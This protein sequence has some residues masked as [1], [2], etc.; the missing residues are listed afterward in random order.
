[1]PF[2]HR[3]LLARLLVALILLAGAACQPAPFPTPTATA[4]SAPAL[5]PQAEA[6]ATALPTTVVPTPAP[7]PTPTPSPTPVANLVAGVP[8][9]QALVLAGDEPRTLDPALSQDTTS[10][11]Y[12]AHLFSGLVRLDEGLRLQPDLAASWESL[13]DGTR[14]VFHLRP[15]ALFHDGKPVTAYDVAFSLE[16]ATSPTLDSPTA[17]TY[18]SD[19][20]GVA[21]KL[22]GKAG[23][24]AGLHVLDDLTLEIV[25]DAPKVY[26][27]AK[28]TYP[29][30]AVVSKE[31]V[32][33]GPEWSRTANGTGPFRL[34]QWL[35]GQQLV[36]ERNPEFYRPQAGVR[37]VVY[38]FL[39]GAPIRLYEQ[40][41]ID[42]AYIG[43]G[44]LPRAQDP[45][46]G[47]GSDL[48]AYGEMS[49]FY[50]G[51]STKKQ[52][53]D[54]PLVRRAFAMALD[55]ERLA[56]AGQQKHLL[57]ANG[58]LPQG[59][60]GY[61]AGVIGFAYDPAEARQ[62]LS[63]SKYGGPE[64]L[65]PIIY[66]SSGIDEVDRALGAAVEQWRA[67][68]GVQ[69]SARL[70]PTQDYF[71]RLPDEVDNLFDFGWIADYP[72]PENILD[73]LF[74]SGTANNIGRYSNAQVDA[75]LEAARVEADE[76]QRFAL[77]RQAQNTL[78]QDAA[79]IPLW[80]GLS[81]MLVKPYVQGFGL[82]AQGIATLEQ[83]W[84]ENRP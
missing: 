1:M 58:F 64:G 46:S 42:A 66:T 30:A 6:S 15:N 81:Y 25:I 35:P 34:K 38:R 21:D 49:I 39:A 68:L 80:H 8:R 70:L 20:V 5:P 83:V 3:H 33:S 23:S 36:L 71:Y 10:H 43:S 44:S 14:Y 67:N 73:V 69:V 77:Y 18:L 28:L 11:E 24:I 7:L 61:T 47:L 52:P 2:L 74:H 82:T 72:D 45:Q 57:L 29:V 13:D 75:L 27:L 22:A 12:T 37:Y 76:G 17:A 50:I 79:A 84:L 32:M 59:M 62:L 53:F 48:R 55:V 54:D 19:I 4:L 65:P 41:G 9:N 78:L 26:F 31:Q 56:G 16:R 51:F 40:G 63:R 60:P